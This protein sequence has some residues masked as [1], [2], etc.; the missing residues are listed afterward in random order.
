[1]DASI[2][3]SWQNLLLR[4]ISVAA[5]LLTSVAGNGL[6][7]APVP[8]LPPVVVISPVP[9]AAKES[10]AALSATV[11]GE[12]DSLQWYEG[13]SGDISKPIAGATGPLLVTP[14]I[15][16]N[17]SFW[18]RATN[19]TG[20][21]D[22]T[23]V[24]VTLI[25][26]EPSRLLATGF[27]SDGQLGDGTRISRSTPGLLASSVA[28]SSASGTHS[29]FVKTDGSLWAV[30]DNSFGQL[31][32]GTTNERV[33]PVQVAANVTAA[34][35]GDSHSLFL[36]ADGSL[37]AM[38]Y[39]GYGQLGDSTTTDRPTP[40]LV[41]Q[42]VISAAAGESHSMFLKSDGSLWAM[43]SNSSG[44]LGDGTTTNRSSPVQ[45]AQ[46]VLQ[47]SLGGYH[48]VFVKSDGSLWATGNNYYSQLGDGTNTNRTIPVQTATGVSRAEA[49]DSFSIF[50]RSNGTLWALG[51]NYYGQ[52]GDGTTTTRSAPVQVAENV[53]AIATGETNSF[54]IKTDNTAWATGTNSEG[55]FGDGTTNSRSTPV[56]VAQNVALISAGRYHTL[57]GDRIPCIA[58]QSPDVGIPVGG[59][60]SL[61]VT[62]SGPGTPSYQWY[63][64]NAGDT[65]A[66]I[67]GATAATYS[68]PAASGS[69]SYWARVSN[70]YG[71]A[72]SRTM[73]VIIVTQPV[74]TAQ[75][76]AVTHSSGESAT[77]SL[78]ASGGYMTYQW[79]QGPRGDTSNPVSGATGALLITP[80]FQTDTSYWARASNGAGIVDS[81]SVAL[82][83]A[84]PVSTRLL[85]TGND[86]YGQLGNETTIGV[87]TP[88]LIATH[89]I[90]SA[91]G[92]NNSFYIRDN[93][94]LWAVGGNV[95]GKLGIGTTENRF[96]AAQV[97]TQ[98]AQVFSGAS[99]S[100]FIKSDH[101]LWGMG[102]NSYGQLGDGTLINR[103]T[104]T[105]LADSVVQASVG[106]FHSLFIKSD[107][108]LWSA[109]RNDGG[110]L[111]DG[112]TTSRSTPFHIADSVAAASAG[113]NH[114]LFLKTDGT[115]WA[116]GGNSYGQLGNGGITDSPTPIQ[117][118]TG[119]ASIAAGEYC[120]FFIKAD[121]SLW[122]TGYNSYGNLG[123]GDNTSI[124]TPTKITDG[125]KSVFC[126]EHHTLF[127]KADNTLWAMGENGSGQYGDG[128]S[129]DH[130]TPVQIAS[131]V[132]SVAAGGS[133]SLFQD[134]RP[135]IDTQPANMGI[136]NSTS[137]TLTLSASAGAPLTYQWY[138]G[139]SGDTSS[140]LSGATAPTYQ[141]PPLTNDTSYW[142]RATNP[143]GSIDSRTTTV[144][145]VTQPTIA[146]APQPPSIS[147]GDNATLSVTAGGGML[148]YQWFQGASGDISLPVAGATGPQMVTPTL[149]A[150]QN[151]WVRISNAA[152]FV[153]SASVAVTVRPPVAGY[154]RSVGSTTYGQLGTGAISSSPIPVPLI[155]GVAK[156]A[157]GSNQA[158]ILKTDGSLWAIKAGGTG[159]FQITTSVTWIACGAGPSAFVK[160]DGTLWR[161]NAASTSVPTQVTTEVSKVWPTYYALYYLKTNGTLVSRSILPP[162]SSETTIATGVASAAA[163]TTR[164]LYV[165]TDGTLWGRGSNSYGEL[166]SSYISYYDSAIQLGSGVAKA[167]IGTYATYF[168]KTDGTLWGMGNN[169]SGQ[170]G[171][172]TTPLPYSYP[173]SLDAGVS[174][175]ASSGS[176]VMYLKTDGS[177]QGLG[178]NS[179]GQL[180]NGSWTSTGTPVL[181]A[182]QVSQVSV[183]SA[184]T[185]F[186]TS[187][188][189]LWSAGAND[190]NQFGNASPSGITSAP[191]T[192]NVIAISAGG[193]HSLILKGDGSLWA[194]GS[195]TYGQLGDGTQITRSIPVLVATNV[196]K[197]SAGTS[198]SLFIKNDG[199]LWGMG[200][201][202][203]NGL[204]DGTTTNRLIPVQIATG[205]SSAYAG[206]SHS[207]FIKTDSTLWAV[208]NNSNGQLG[209]GTTTSQ[210]TPVQIATQVVA[211][212]AGNYHSLF[213]K[214][215]ASLWAAGVNS[216]GQLGDGTTVQRYTPIQVATGVTRVSARNNFS[217][218]LKSDGSLWSTGDNS[219]GQLGDGST[220]SRSTPVQVATGVTRLSA[221]ADF[222]LF[223]KSD[224]T[225]WA[226]GYNSAYQLGDGTTTNRST[227]VQ[228]ASQIIGASGGDSHSLWLTTTAG[229][230]PPGIAQHPGSSTVQANKS[231][232]LSVTAV[233]TGLLTYQWYS[234]F[235]GDTSTPMA[236]ATSAGFVTP[237]A[238]VS[239]SYWVRVTGAAGTVD[240]RSARVT[241]LAA[242]II[243]TQ[244]TIS[245][246]PNGGV[247]FTV[248]AVANAYSYQWYSS[249]QNTTLPVPGG[250]STTVLTPPVRK[251]TYFWLKVTNPSGSSSSQEVFVS[252][253]PVAGRYLKVAGNSYGT[254]L[255]Q[256]TG[257][258]TSVSTSSGHCL[259][260]K[261]SGTLWGFG[262]NGYLQLG[263]GNYTSISTPA[264]IAD[265]VVSASAGASHSLFIKTDGTLW[266][267]GSN[268]YGQLG[269]GTNFTPGAP[270]LIAS[271]VVS[272]SAGYDHSLF[273]KSDGTLWAMGNNS[274]GKLGDSTLTSR[275]TPV[276]IATSVVMAAA[277]HDHSLFLKS[278]GSVWGV[279]S[280]SYSQLG[281]TVSSTRIPVKIADGVAS[282]TAGDY[283][284]LLVSADG[285]LRT[286]G[287]NQYGQ[288]GYGATDNDWTKGPNSF[289]VNIPRTLP[290]IIAGNV[291][292]AAAG[293]SHSL[294]VTPDG[295]KL[296]KYNSL[297]STKADG[298]LWASGYNSY[299]QL[300]TSPTT[301][302]KPPAK[303]QDRI[304][305]AAAGGNNTAVLTTS[306]TL[307]PPTIVTDP[308]STIVASGD[309]ATF[310][311]TATG[312]SLSYQWYT[313][314]TGD[315]SSPIADSNHATCTIPVLSSG[316]RVWVKVTNSAAYSESRSATALAGD[317]SAAY[318][319]WANSQGLTDITPGGDPDGDQRSNL[320]EYATGSAGGIAD[321]APSIDVITQPT[322]RAFH[323]N[324][325]G[326]KDLRYTCLLTPD[327]VSWQAIPLAFIDQVWTSGDPALTVTDA[328]Q[329]PENLWTLTLQTTASPG[330]LFLKVQV[331]M[332]Q[333]E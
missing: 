66:P 42:N 281:T 290:R 238:T 135:A 323:L 326:D 147:T 313:G 231:V 264:K 119:V 140:P 82:T 86:N 63:L 217:Q 273:I 247:S 41:A 109:G 218:F 138:L 181:T 191:V 288:L 142:V 198:H 199:T 151:F 289:Y 65:S 88:I 252:S 274:N 83:T 174:D 130:Y 74:I 306:S 287:R 47:V 24:P 225:L 167:A 146:T 131:A 307:E 185:L 154:L 196:A 29:L 169:T 37:W 25:S 255:T 230:A 173:I 320:L 98:A 283:H 202:L 132:T 125:V 76:M 19:I 272:A 32:D 241:L 187:D 105:P 265:D 172:S 213:L 121:G 186:V 203:S 244:P 8:T 309:P 297:I 330:R 80:P 16:G 50:I 223:V 254:N 315:T 159:P 178:L 329:G 292:Q 222:S 176:Q 224:S 84:A 72:D 110:Q 277:G 133:H 152:G 162:S 67:S 318:L 126:G 240:S 3:Q 116:M 55:E 239:A 321:A 68:T 91:A 161:I 78:S 143:Y 12:T 279:G 190:Y 144:K 30:G 22:S 319:S 311:V 17:S 227:P 286:M 211:A 228:V 49:G 9:S 62:A 233:G 15:R 7:A 322:T 275:N 27:N 179:S 150:G 106:N 35:A 58:S 18:L 229:S 99:H 136:I 128:T 278:D 97:A 237:A 141:T 14:P 39:N 165:K 134:L 194:C 113:N 250:T 184:T 236:T 79:F 26:P 11:T 52:L 96:I 226:T 201:N 107:G 45:I 310:T 100:L 117:V 316:T 325:R 5:F 284:S 112:T 219:Y 89:V 1:M 124:T 118:A 111:G 95:Y 331:E 59:T 44:Q 101:T 188:G 269:N 21:T 267:M 234:G 60:T 302:L 34:F 10:S 192:D 189:T 56:Q 164:L 171:S 270:A 263:V 53:T 248:P 232:T 212:A 221:G 177:L 168:V 324:L 137:T 276:Q 280:N 259:F 127:V 70:S 23:A 312:D 327:L 43:G 260:V 51:Y 271:N 71:H 81:Q 296:A 301:A 303:N 6:H 20:T 166:G 122:A 293:T 73:L 93:G 193:S 13:T 205:V 317:A 308:V 249:V 268:G 90:R 108:S 294:W 314:N 123:T 2:G 182:R 57:I 87:S 48:S 92:T 120:S 85:A 40:V 195:N 155:T 291:N 208:G 163:D 114:S 285:T 102:Y 54:F 158:L 197:A 38:G 69:Q 251:N 75:P 266:A 298:G 94:D 215:D 153:D 262:S 246:L 129:T 157:A 46:N 77:L 245:L 31:G 214:T 175:V 103:L 209:T 282:I 200:Y 295:G 333:E 235:S 139:N 261:T 156:V 33:T 332:G 299:G 328:T 216:Y 305:L 253:R 300:C 210:A 160:S 28:S 170:L 4:S 61:A 220:N 183:G 243:T 304:W 256:R 207:L 206:D 145:I 180:G 36:K 242:P 149:T 204:G 104:P 258:V 257:A 115:L 148:V 64:G